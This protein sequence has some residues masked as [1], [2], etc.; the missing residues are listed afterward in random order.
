MSLPPR[1]QISAR[2]DDPNDLDAAEELEILAVCADAEGFYVDPPDPV[3][4]HY[5]LRGCAPEGR[6]AA[7]AAQPREDGS[8]P[9]GLL[10]VNPLDENGVRGDRGWSEWFLA[11]VRVLG[12]RPSAEDPARVDI[13]VEGCLNSW[14]SGDEDQPEVPKAP[15][16]SRGF[17]LLDR[18]DEFWGPCRE[19]ALVGKKQPEPDGEPLRLLGCA[20]GGR[21]V[22]AL[23]TG[24]E[25]DLGGVFL[26]VLDRGGRTIKK[27]WYNLYVD[28][29]KPSARGPGLVDLT[30]DVYAFDERKAAAEHVHAIWSAGPPAEP[31]RWAPL[32]AAGRTAW[33]PVAMQNGE[34][35]RTPDAPPG[36][37]YHL[38]GRHI[39]DLPGF[40]CALGE[41]MN[42][43]GAYFGW[44]L[45]TVA[46]CL[47]GG[48]GVKGPFTLVWHD[49][50]VAR[51]CLGLSPLMYHEQETFE[52]LLEL[53]A[54]QK[55]EVVLA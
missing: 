27:D 30:L 50:H 41:A 24:D 12:V 37:T 35:L 43:P 40:L 19:V 55:I 2:A 33:I 22:A 14:E 47:M 8:S 26:S 7:A 28:A 1:I 36:G 38:D 51:R 11:D 32:D 52:N 9:V 46:D 31:N 16:R 4:D 29:W 20:P 5:E 44:D 42:G 15:P 17:H 45:Y 25:F 23:E 18:E 6:L 49:H 21:L 34:A 10:I 39:T 54:E 53:F 48:F 13:T 3:R